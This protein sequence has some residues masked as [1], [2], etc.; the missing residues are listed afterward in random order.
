MKSFPHISQA[1]LKTYS[2]LLQKKYR[3]TEGRF[4]VEGVH[5]VEE[6]L[7][8]EW[9]VDVVLISS[10][11]DGKDVA[12]QIQ[13]RAKSKNVEVVEVTE[14]E[15]RKL[16]DAVTVQGVLGVVTV[17]EEHDEPFWKTLPQKSV[18]VAL[19]AISDPGNVG[20]ILRTC[21]W[22]NVDAVLLSQ[23][24]VDVYNPKVVR[25]TMGAIFHLR[26]K[27]ETDLTSEVRSAKQEGFHVLVTN[28]QQGISL[29]SMKV[30][31]RSF[32]I[33]GNEAR[34]VSQEL[35]QGADEIISIPRYGKAES[36]NVAVSCGIVLSRMKMTS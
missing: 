29:D 32:L 11:F 20:T 25:S 10:K 23:N 13:Q 30:P 35:L 21:D 4:I 9:V 36:L 7:S 24:S 27:P 14:R 19:D 22:F 34:G 3:R 2:K 31:Q 17:K 6:A 8:S 33:F 18:V 1:Q 26:I 16:S 28:V 5:L 15:I 12:R